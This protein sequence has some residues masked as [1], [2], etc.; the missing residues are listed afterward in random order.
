MTT[1]ESIDYVK[2][3]F[4]S[5]SDN[6]RVHRLRQTT[7]V[8]TLTSESM[9]EPPMI[10]VTNGKPA[11]KNELAPRREAIKPVAKTPAAK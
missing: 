9:Y 10:N 5:F 1:A 7:A 3:L 6:S 4:V 11:V 2:S 8:A